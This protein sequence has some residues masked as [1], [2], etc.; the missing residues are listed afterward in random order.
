VS[1]FALATY[2]ILWIITVLLTVMVLL[3]YRQ[4]GLSWMRGRERMSLHGLDVGST[5]PAVTLN[6]NGRAALPVDW[7]RSARPSVAVFALP[8]CPICKQLAER[9]AESPAPANRIERFWFDAEPPACSEDLERAGWRVSVSPDEAAHR[10]FEVGG[11]PFAYAI[12]ARG[13]IAAKGLVNHPE[14]VDELAAVAA[15]A[16]AATSEGAV[17]NA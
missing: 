5:A 17:A 6:G 13:R 15:E 1:G 16:S 7:Q 10:A 14:D 11:L 12:D 2:I 4:F 3:L 9:L 8:S